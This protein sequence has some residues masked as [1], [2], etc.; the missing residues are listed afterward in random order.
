MVAAVLRTRRQSG[1]KWHHPVR[2]DEAAS[3][4]SLTPRP[5]LPPSRQCMDGVTRTRNLHI[6]EPTASTRCLRCMSTSS[7]DDLTTAG[8]AFDSASSVE[9]RCR[10][11]GDVECVT[12][13]RGMDADGFVLVKRRG[14]GKSSER[15]SRRSGAAAATS[16]AETGEVL[17]RGLSAAGDDPSAGAVDALV[18]AITALQPAVAASPFCMGMRTILHWLLSTT[19]FGNWLRLYAC[20]TTGCDARNTARH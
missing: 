6:D 7:I 3:S 17:S 13:A 18:D 16:V 4:I 14:H 1:S 11:L 5:L 10:R 15:R 12:V 20:R 8:G 2:R 9:R 19:S